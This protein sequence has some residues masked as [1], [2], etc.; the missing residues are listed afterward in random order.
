VSALT[1]PARFNGPPGTAHGG[2]ACGVVAEAIGPGATVRLA[3]PPPLDV[4]LERRR[5]TDGTVRLSHAGATVA[6]GRP[7]RPQVEPPAPPSWTAASLA[8][9]GFSVTAHPFPTCFA[10]GPRREYDGLRL[11]PGRAGP[12]GLLASPWRPTGDLATSVGAVDP[13]FVWAALDCPAGFACI[14][15]GSIALLGTMTAELVEPVLPGRD[16]IVA[17]WPLGGAGRRHRAGAVLYEREG[18]LVAL[19]E[20]VWITLR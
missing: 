3:L 16:Y 9:D 20:S 14:A 10:C 17:A 19:A 12:G 1:I 18:G 15:P 4:P 2:Y 5:D 6:E 8:A 7:G 11:A 13:R